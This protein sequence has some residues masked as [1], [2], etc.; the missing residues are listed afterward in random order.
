MSHFTDHAHEQALQ[1]TLHWLDAPPQTP[2]QQYE[3]ADFQHRLKDYVEA[4]RH[5]RQAAQSGHV[6]AQYRFAICLQQGLGLPADRAAAEHWFRQAATAEKENTDAG[7]LYRRAMCLTYGWGQ[8]VDAE[9]GHAVFLQLGDSH[10]EALYELGISYQIGRGSVTA[11]RSQAARYF[12]AAYD[13]L[14]EEAIFRLY[15]VFDGPF[16]R[17]PYARELT[18]AFSFHLGQLMRVAELSPGADSLTRLADFYQRGYPGDSPE[19]TAKFRRLAQKHYRRA[20]KFTENRY[21]LY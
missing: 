3:Y 16:S 1:E 21:T 5:F 2:A 11:D 10:P 20:Q 15:E 17:F 18:E 9:A 8:A 4:A 7:S 19:Q 14:C 12:R 6:P 13:R